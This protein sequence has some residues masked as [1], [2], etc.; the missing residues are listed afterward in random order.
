M[1]GGCLARLVAGYVQRLVLGADPAGGTQQSE[2]GVEENDE[3]L[4][5]IFLGFLKNIGLASL[6]DVDGFGRTARTARTAI[7]GFRGP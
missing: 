2:V 7:R 5:Q 1:P 4:S 6:L 3:A